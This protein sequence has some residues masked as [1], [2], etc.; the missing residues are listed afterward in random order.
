L[1]LLKVGKPKGRLEYYDENGVIYRRR[2]NGKPQLVVPRN[3]V[4]EVIALN[5]D[6]TSAA[7]PGRKLTFQTLCLRYYW[8][9]MRQDVEKYVS[10]CDGCLR[11]KRKSEYTAPSGEVRQPTYPF[12]ITSL[13]A[14]VSVHFNFSNLDAY[15]VSLTFGVN[16]PEVLRSWYNHLSA[17]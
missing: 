8:P 2:K 13:D 9:G 15:S 16:S 17:M 12:E 1:Q 14:V 6:P 11:I 7:H 5:H 10:Q 3:L 4:K